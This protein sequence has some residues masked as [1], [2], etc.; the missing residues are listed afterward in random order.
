MDKRITQPRNRTALMQHFQRLVTTGH[1]FWCTDQ[2]PY[3][4]LQPLIDKWHP[5]LA[6]RADAP[7][8]A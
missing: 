7:A 8:R 4:R 2:I 1:F 3:T 6:L 5:E